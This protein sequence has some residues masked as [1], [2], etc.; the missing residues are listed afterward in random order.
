MT[1]RKIGGHL[2]ISPRHL[3]KYLK[4]QTELSKTGRRRP[5]AEL[6]LKD[7]VIGQTELQEAL[8]KQRMERL[9]QNML[10]SGLTRKDLLRIRSYIQE[11]FIPKDETF[12]EQDTTG[13]CF[14]LLV[15]G[16]ILVLRTSESGEE[17]PLETLLPGDCIGEMGYF[18][19]G[20]RS[21]SA[22]AVEDTVLMGISYARLDTIF[23]Q[24]PALA[25]NFLKIVTRRLRDMN[26]RFQETTKQS[27]VLQ[28]TIG[29]LKNLMDM[30]EL[31][32][33]NTGIEGLIT[34]VVHL[35]SLTL[36]AD[37][38]TLFLIDPV[39]GQLWSKVAEGEKKSEIRIPLQ[40]GVAG[41]VARQRKIVSIADAY[42][43]RRFNPEVDGITGYRT[44][45]ILCGP[46][47]NLNGELLGVIEIINKKNGIFSRQDE[48]LFNAFSSQCAITLENFFLAK[49]MINHYEQMALL[50]D[51]ATAIAQRMDLDGLIPKIVE[52]ISQVLQAE[53]STL[54]L[55][56]SAKQ[57]LWSKV[58]QGVLIS[59]IRFPAS[60]GLA[61]HVAQ[62]G[63]ILNI[64]DA[65]GDPRFNQGIDDRT[66]FKT[67]SVLCI[68]IRNRQG[69][70]IGVMEVMNKIKG[71]FQ[72][73]D[74]NLL[75]T[76]SSQLAVALENALLFEKVIKMKNYLENIQES[77]SNGI[78][79]LNSSGEII[80]AN[81]AALSLFNKS[82]AQIAGKDIRKIFGKSNGPAIGHIESVLTSQAPA[83]DYNMLLKLRHG[84]YAV[85]MTSA[86]LS[87][88]K[89]EFEGAVLAIED[90]TQEK[91]LH[92]TLTRYM[93]KDIVERLLADPRKQSLGG[94]R[95][96][97]TILF[98]DIRGF[99]AL[100]ESLSAEEAV[101]LLNDTFG[102]L[103]G[104]VMK[105]NG[106][107]DKY[108]GDALMAVFGIP[109]AAF[110]DAS[111][112][113]L[114]GLEMLQKMKSFNAL[115]KKK[116]L[117]PVRIG[118]GISTGEVISGNI[119]SEKRMDFTVIGDDVNISQFLEKLNKLYGT[120]LL[121]SESTHRELE[122]AFRTRLI[123]RV[124]FKGR[125]K[126]V[127]IFE[128]L[129]TAD[130]QFRS[131]TETTF[132]KAM[133]LYQQQRFAEAEPLFE[134]SAA[135][136]PPSRVFRKRCRH[137]LAYPP[138]ADWDGVW[139]VQS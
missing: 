82:F 131:E 110:D 101:A 135:T 42:Q 115:R 65:Y 50:L 44:Q 24:V 97:A 22:R 112:A 13:D 20:S 104:S 123:D 40:S 59:E 32:T 87:D 12:I 7:G 83:T 54:F 10:C 38:A 95:S 64:P 111:R 46:V 61:G 137:F 67:R 49:K 81:S 37:R 17:T 71:I 62:T 68:P 53:R 109:F 85:N 1:G 72:K 98:S 94:S 69:E 55:L 78:I 39:A 2:E 23:E 15:S 27:H 11:K 102:L 133:D 138:A 25:L 86:A 130:R 129:G 14:Y 103:T 19:G 5:L 35:A 63:E 114:S 9:A 80:T 119:G 79:S 51:V 52:K 91:R 26:L 8:F 45:S 132:S 6:L 113:V 57:E 30:T 18:S 93:A 125:R 74:E 139:V 120:G 126:P 84:N 116:N 29:N 118:I 96:K 88:S 56:D 90:I 73:E 105:H 33:P 31:I 66:S 4:R 89:G 117:E 99:T 3:S 127:Q 134:K 106:I 47:I 60:L 28:T 128:V 136:D 108:I 36:H 92:S 16:Q 76:I 77:I 100:T 75:V 122:K 34:R 58:A 70:I 107:L 121:V 43:D 48:D 124:L 41:W 21:A